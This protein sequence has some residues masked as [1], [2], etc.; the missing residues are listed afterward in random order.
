[1]KTMAVIVCTH[2]R[3]KHL[4]ECIKSLRKLKNPPEYKVKLAVI[5]SSDKKLSKEYKRLADFYRWDKNKISLSEK[6]NLAIKSIKADIIAFTDDDCIA[7]ASWLAELVKGF[8][9]GVMCVTG[10][11]VPF[12]GSE[13][14]A[15]ERKFSF[16]RIGTRKRA[17]Q[18][19]IGLQNLWRFGHGNNMAFRTAVFKRVGLFDIN[20]GVGSKGLRAEDVDM[21][22]RI[23][24]AGHR[25]VFNPAASVYHK[26]LIQEKDVPKEA[27]RNGYASKLVLFKHHDLNCL[28]LYFGGI[29][30]LAA[31]SI[32]SNLFGKELE[33]KTNIELLRGWLGLK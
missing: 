14:T 10:R 2:N 21:F 33:K 22:Y 27:F 9:E 19:H 29:V 16:D 15:Y 17:I 5:D 7:T 12:A 26:H 20:L 23:Y 3:E 28:A 32:F 13:R 18:K 25:L 31:K 11:T 30:K 1:M 6:R 8:G 4:I 24:K